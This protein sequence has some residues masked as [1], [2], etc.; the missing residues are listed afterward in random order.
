MKCDKFH[1]MPGNTSEG[2]WITVLLCIIGVFLC[3]LN[4]ILYDKFKYIT[5]L[6]IFLGLFSFIFT[7]IEISHLF[8]RKYWFRYHR[9]LAVTLLL[10]IYYALILLIIY[11]VVCFQP[12]F[13]TWDI[14]YIYFPLFLMP[15]I[16]VL[17]ILFYWFLLAVG[18]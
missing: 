16:I 5:P 17:I 1:R 13:L 3:V 7:Y 14:T 4:F 18:G 10:L 12:S 9:N 8:I 2:K 6:M 11:L 15:P